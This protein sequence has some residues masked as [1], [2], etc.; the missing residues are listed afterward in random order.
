MQRRLLALALALQPTPTAVELPSLPLLQTLA[1]QAVTLTGQHRTQASKLVKL[2]TSSL[3]ASIALR[4]R[5][6]CLKQQMH[7]RGISMSAS[8]LTF[9][10][11][12]L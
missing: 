9:F 8:Q 5:T 4:P 12:L 1:G 11:K 2:A 6:A 10:T 3:L 7:W